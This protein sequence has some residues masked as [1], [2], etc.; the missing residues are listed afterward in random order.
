MK[1]VADEN[2]PLISHYFCANNQM[3]LKPGRSITHEDLLDA[4]IL[5]VRSVTKVNRE[6]LH[7]T[8]VKFVGS[9]T[10]GLDH[11]D[12]QWLDQAGI[13]WSSAYGCNAQA[14]VEYVLCVIAAL[15]LKEMFPKKKIRAGVIGVGLIGSKVVEKLK[16]LGCEVVQCDP[17]RAE[18]ENDF[19]STPL[20][21]FSNLDLVTLHVPLTTAGK[22]PTKH[23]IQADFLQRQ[24]AGCV[25]LNASRGSVIDFSDL[26][27][28]GGHLHWC[29][30]VWENEPN[31]DL[32]VLEKAVISTPHIA[33][34]SVQS[35]YR[36]V[37]MIYDAAVRM[38]VLTD[39]CVLPV[40]FPQRVLSFDNVAMTWQD[41]ALKIYD[42]M[43]TTQVMKQSLLSG[44]MT[45]DA[46][47]KSFPE[48]YE[49][50]YV[51]LVDVKLS[52][53]DRAVL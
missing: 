29:L 51:N 53:E 5:L 18:V 50:A 45:F 34:Y 22:Y 4:D 48:R 47:R 28:Y 2:I 10:T 44:S 26:K 16:L 14:V 15:Q 7:D 42:P 39:F 33:G 25:L 30:D 11:L 19:V 21:E 20:A 40:P 37:Q 46:L 23:M 35:K 3:I 52:D 43:L 31:I 27:K 1:I 49:F 9:A 17:L 38:E 36:G 32:E 12:S 6:L 8:P 24:K 41:V 13:F